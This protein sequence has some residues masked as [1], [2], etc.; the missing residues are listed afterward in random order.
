[1]NHKSTVPAKVKPNYVNHK[2]TVPAKVKP[3]YFSVMEISLKLIHKLF[4]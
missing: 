4:P 2:S 1:V 3:N